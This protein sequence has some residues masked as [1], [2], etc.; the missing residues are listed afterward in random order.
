MRIKTFLVFGTLLV[1]VIFSGCKTNLL[2]GETPA[3]P[4]PQAP[5]VPVVV[6]GT[7]TSYADVVDRTSPAVV[8]IEAQVKG[9]HN[10]R[11]SF[12]AVTI[13]F[14]NFR[15]RSSRTAAHS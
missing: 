7:R 14:V 3:A 13:S 1:A 2:G 4:V 9:R 5:V 12:Q 15:H 10:R 11:L 6:E 8:R